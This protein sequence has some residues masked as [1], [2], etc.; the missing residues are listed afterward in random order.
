[1]ISMYIG[2]N[3]HYLIIIFFIDFQN[4]LLRLV[5]KKAILADNN[6]IYIVIRILNKCCFLKNAICK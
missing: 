5:I 6:V 1:M 2:I 3:L 4:T